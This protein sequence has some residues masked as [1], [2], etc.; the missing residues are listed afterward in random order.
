MRSHTLHKTHTEQTHTKC[1]TS[2]TKKKLCVWAECWILRSKV[3][4][5][6]VY[7]KTDGLTF[8]MPS[9]WAHL[10]SRFKQQKRRKIGENNLCKEEKMTRTLGF[11]FLFCC[12]HLKLGQKCRWNIFIFVRL[13]E[14]HVSIFLLYRKRG[15]HRI[16]CFSY[17]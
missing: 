3:S 13:N 15:E 6:F 12:L 8:S 17:F 11:R 10:F 1:I 16:W 2:N 14:I 4:F 7:M 5:I 9:D